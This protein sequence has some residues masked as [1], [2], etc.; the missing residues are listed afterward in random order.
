MNMMKDGLIS[1]EEA[2]MRVTPEQI[3]S[4]LHPSLDPKFSENEAAKGLPA[5]PGAVSGVI[6]LTADEA[7]AL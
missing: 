2:V 5:S 6:A 4:L 1:E 3:E 7:V